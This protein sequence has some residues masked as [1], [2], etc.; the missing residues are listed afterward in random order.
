MR[1]LIISVIACCLIASPSESRA[2]EILAPSFGSPAIAGNPDRLRV[3][4]Q[5][6]DA[7]H[8]AKNDITANDHRRNVSDVSY[9]QTLLISPADETSL[10]R[11]QPW[12]DDVF[13]PKLDVPKAII[14]VGAVTVDAEYLQDELLKS[15][16]ALR[17]GTGENDARRALQL[18]PDKTY[19]IEVNKH[20]VGS[21]GFYNFGAQI[22]SEVRR[23]RQYFQFEIAPDGRVFGRGVSDSGIY[24]IVPTPDPSILLVLEI[25]ELVVSKSIRVD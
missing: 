12:V 7:L 6:G 2:R 14:R 8:V 17:Q 21:T 16:Q 5:K 3:D 4:M 20:R 25:D 23:D 13:L 11:I 24:S 15:F 22:V 1:P 18:F 19:I 9:R 10:S